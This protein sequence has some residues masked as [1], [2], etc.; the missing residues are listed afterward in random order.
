ME[1]KRKKRKE[2][3]GRGRKN[4]MGR[5]V[6]ERENRGSEREMDGWVDRRVA[7]WTNDR[8]MDGG[9]VE[10]IETGKDTYIGENHILDRWINGP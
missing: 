5:E 9:M 1:R 4:E 7:R 6:K 8:R 2:R 10:G 3:K